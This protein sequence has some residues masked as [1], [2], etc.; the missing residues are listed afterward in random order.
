MK[1]RRLPAALGRR[2]LVVAS[3]GDHAHL[4]GDARRA[5]KDGADLIEI[6]ADLFPKTQLKPEL[7]RKTLKTVKDA[8]R[9][10]LF[11]TLRI[12]EEGGGLS[13]H[14]REQDRLALFRAALS[15]VQGVDVE[16]SANEINRH[17]EFEA[18]KRGR[19]V[20]LSAHDFK[21]TPSNTVVSG[22]TRKAKRLGGD[23]LKVAA[24]PRRRA[25]VD[26]WMEA[27]A[28][29]PFRRRV[30][31]A[32]GPLGEITRREGFRWNSCLTY[33]YIRRRVAPGQLPVKV[34]AEA[35]RSLPQKPK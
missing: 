10:P 9:C 16:L 13:P 25:D 32:M 4:A 12:G 19:F 11:L 2:A 27:C 6:R 22:L 17:V 23:V 18:H 1:A 35:V 31:I 5:V 21:K 34:L 3:L 20:V 33:G 7:L 29:S 14:F 8:V 28:K 26:R 30:F 15:D 24:T